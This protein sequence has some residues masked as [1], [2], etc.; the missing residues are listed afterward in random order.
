METIKLIKIRGNGA[1]K[2]KTE[3]TK[4]TYEKYMQRAESYKNAGRPFKNPF[5]DWWPEDK[6]EELEEV[7]TFEE[8]IKSKEESR[9]EAKVSEGKELEEVDISDQDEKLLE[10]LDKL[11][12]FELKKYANDELGMELPKSIKK[13]ELLKQIKEQINA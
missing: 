5:A 6:V 3:V 11:K 1:G 13:A 8:K 10:E 12:Y 7:E 4:H 2:H 9:L